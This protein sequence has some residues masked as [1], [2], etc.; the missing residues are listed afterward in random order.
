[1]N[2]KKSGI[3]TI[4]G[5]PNV[6]KSTLTNTLAGEKVAIVSPK[7]QTTGQHRIDGLVGDVRHQIHGQG[8]L[9]RPGHPPAHRAG[10][11]LPFGPAQQREQAHRLQGKRK[12][13][14]LVLRQ[15]DIR[16]A[17]PVD[18]A[19]EAL[20]RLAPQKTKNAQES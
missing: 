10:H 20:V 19:A 16:L 7:P 8:Q 11:P 6:G 3:I 4:C 5:R 13:P 12:T 9:G 1:M 2:I 14:P 15:P 18:W 17:Q